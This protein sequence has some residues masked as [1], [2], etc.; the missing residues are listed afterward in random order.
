MH[1]DAMFAFAEGLHRRDI[2]FN[3]YPLEKGYRPCDVAVT[4]G[5]NKRS[6][7]RGRMVGDIA[8]E[9]ARAVAHLS[10]EQRRKSHLVIERGFIHRDRYFMMG[11]GGLNGRARYFNRFSSSD[12][13][14]QLNVPVDP[15]RKTGEHIVLCGQVPWDASV[16]HVDHV[17]WCQETARTLRQLT[18]RKIIFRPHPLAKDAIEMQGPGI[19]VVYSKADSLLED[20]ENAWAVVTFSSN[21]GVEATLAGVPAFVCDEGAMGYPILNK[22]L[23]RIE[24]PIK[25]DRTQWLFDLAYTQWTLEEAAMGQPVIHLWERQ[26]MTK[27]FKQAVTMFCGVAPSVERRAA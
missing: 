24:S 9:H 3:L 16:Q 1:I 22:D 8:E 13:W 7:P 27:R 26:S 6:T 4:F 11:W 21:A 15:W 10:R 25:P 5:I 14:M 2:P 12:R 18:S 20:M 23:H 19:D 17:E